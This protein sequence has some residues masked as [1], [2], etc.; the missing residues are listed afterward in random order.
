MIFPAEL[1][2]NNSFMIIP[3]EFVKDRTLTQ[4]EI[5]ALMTPDPEYLKAF[6]A[7]YMRKRNIFQRIRHF[8][9]GD[10][11]EKIMIIKILWNNLLG[12]RLYSR[13]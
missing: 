1:E 3:N 7:K 9:A 11:A 10:R 13:Y 12:R 8:L 5:T 2:N 6:M 4:E